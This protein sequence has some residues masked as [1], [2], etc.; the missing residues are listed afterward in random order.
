M[1]LA[2]GLR[3]LEDNL[4]LRELQEKEDLHPQQEVPII[5]ATK[6]AHQT[7]IDHINQLPHQEEAPLQQ[8]DLDLLEKEEINIT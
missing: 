7:Q 5:K 6:E 3:K 8:E 4:H 1:L 2:I